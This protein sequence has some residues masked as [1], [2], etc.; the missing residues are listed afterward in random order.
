[1]EY[2]LVEAMLTSPIYT[3][4]CIVKTRWFS[5]WKKPRFVAEKKK[6]STLTVQCSYRGQLQLELMMVMWMGMSRGEEADGR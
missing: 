5:L 1:M 4:T 3:M 2:G 6:K